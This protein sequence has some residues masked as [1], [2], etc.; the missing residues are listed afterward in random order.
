MSMTLA[1]PQAVDAQAMPD[2]SFDLPQPCGASTWKPRQAGDLTGARCH[3]RDWIYL[4][5]WRDRGARVEQRENPDLACPVPKAK[6][7]FALR[8][9]PRSECAPV[10][11]G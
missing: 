4:L 9:K 3:M 2:L 6:L 7:P 10:P 11:F 8:P 5:C 1:R